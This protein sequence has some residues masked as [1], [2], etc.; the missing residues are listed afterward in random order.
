MSASPSVARR[1]RVLAVDHTAGVAPFRRKF[2]AIARHA[3]VDLTVLAPDRWVENYRTVRFRARRSVAADGYRIRAGGVIWPGYENRGFFVSGL[4]GAIREARPD[5]LHLWE[6]PFSLIALQALLARRA[7]APGAKAIFHSADNWS[8]DF[9]YVYRPSR[10]YA[11]IERF[12]HRECAAATAVSDDVV[13]VLRAKGYRGPIDVIPFGLDLDDYADPPEGARAAF[14]GAAAARLG[15][16]PPVVG[17]LGRLT[18]QK[19]IDTLLRAFASLGRGAGGAS[20]APGPAGP[21]TLAIVGEGPARGDLEAL[22]GT[23]GLGDRLRFLPPVP[24]ADVPAVLAAFDALVLPSRT[25]PRLVE[26]FGRVLIEGMAA[27]SVV[28]GSSSGAI[29]SVIGDAG[30]VFPEGDAAALGAAIARALGE[31]GLAATLRAKGRER[32]RRLYTWDA[33]AERVVAIYRRLVVAPAPPAPR[34]PV[35]A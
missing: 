6:E 34:A 25:T 12:A 35:T 4:L 7:L 19:G 10:L 9:R 29:P 32:V 3:D 14:A 27:G 26:Q 23:L 31:P 33:V 15:L 17:Y 21:A 24:H 22:A 1:I 8:R 28:I 20:A 16:V 18:E 11:R 2:A 30:L 13:S 5:V